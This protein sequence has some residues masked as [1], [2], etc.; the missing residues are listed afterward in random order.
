MNSPEKPMSLTDESKSQIAIEYAYRLRETS[1]ARSVF[2]VYANNSARFEQ[3]YRS[4]ATAAKIPGV[5]DPKAD[6]LNLVYQWLGSDQ[7][8]DWLMILDNADDAQIFFS[9]H[10]IPTTH[11]DAAVIESPCLSSFLP[12]TGLGS[13]IITSRDEGTALRLTGL[14]RKQ[15]LQVDIMSEDDTMALLTKRLP[16]DPSD[17]SAKRKL[18]AELD[19]IPLAITQASAYIK[20]RGKRMTIARYLEFLRSNEKNQIDLLSKNEMDL[21]RDPEVP[22]SIIRTWQISFSRIKEQNPAAA[23]LLSCMCMLD[24]QG[25]PEFLFYEDGVQSLRFLEAIET[26]INFSFVVEEKEKGNFEIHRLVQLATQKWLETFGT[27]QKA[28]EKALRL[29]S[30]HYPSGGY[31]NWTTCEAL[32][33]HAQ[34]VMGYTFDSENCKLQQKELLY[35]GAG[36]AFTRGKYKISEEKVTK[37]IEIGEKYLRPDDLSTLDSL[38]VLGLTYLHQGRWSQA[39]ALYLRVIETRKEVLGDRHPDTLTSLNNLAMTYY[40]QGHYKKA[41]EMHIQVLDIKKQVLGPEH[42]DT[43][44]SMNNLASTY[45]DQQDLTKAEELLIQIVDTEKTVLGPKHPVT[46][47]SMNNLASTYVR[48]GDLTEAE[49]LLIQIVD[50]AKRVLGPEHPDTLRSMN[51]L[52]STYREQGH[53]SKA[54]NLEVQV[55]ETQ[56]RILGAE[57]PGTLISMNNL[58]LT[59][60][61]QGHWSKA[62]KLNVQVLNTQK[63]ILG[64]EHPN[65]LISM[66]NLAYT[67]H[68][69]ARHNQA[70]ELMEQVVELFKK[71]LGA[72]HPHTLASIDTLRDWKDE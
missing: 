38:H 68:S 52:A 5:E 44:A 56:K 64:A 4:I 13:I 58:A 7:S 53:C 48:Q 26:L 37:A 42:R 36:F 18:I 1:P 10:V 33:P 29:V 41:E 70:I 12:Q 14:E 20:L 59:Y 57:H 43:L 11:N 8:G 69:Q 21:R 51:N 31:E 61:Y 23:K 6:V 24:R 28:K 63:R 40:R 15:V 50:T 34:I 19:S 32:E 65:T 45:G 39:E 46:L 22:N 47:R 16:E 55:L 35:N 9:P 49:K 30:Y 17:E 27:I 71:K 54:E 67:Y 2:W 72:N 60:G 66:N 62:E 25:I 3:S